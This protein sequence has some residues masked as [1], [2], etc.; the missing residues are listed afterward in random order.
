MVGHGKL[1][2]C[3]FEVIKCTVVWPHNCVFISSIDTQIR[4]CL[5]YLFVDTQ[6]ANSEINQAHEILGG[7]KCDRSLKQTC[8]QYNV[9]S[10]LV[11]LFYIQTID[12]PAAQIEWTP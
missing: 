11:L 5:N 4:N 10:T 9:A 1:P 6:H 2:H 7:T 8:S 12:T 3:L